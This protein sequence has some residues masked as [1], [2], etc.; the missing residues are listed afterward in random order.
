MKISKVTHE[1][2]KI[3]R[4]PKFTNMKVFYVEQKYP[5]RAISQ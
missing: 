3:R 2:I 4:F 5:D 1:I